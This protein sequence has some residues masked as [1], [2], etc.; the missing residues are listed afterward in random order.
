MNR[1]SISSVMSKGGIYSKASW[2]WSFTDGFVGNIVLKFTEGMA[3]GIFQTIA[4]EL[5][6]EGPRSF[7]GQFKPVMKKIY[8]RHDWQEYGERL[9][10]WA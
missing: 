6:E 4:A 3:K 5:Q 9:R 2:T 7:S 10:C 8:A 1:G